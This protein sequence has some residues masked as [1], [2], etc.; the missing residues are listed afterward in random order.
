MAE[1]TFYPSTSRKTGP[2]KFDADDFYQRNMEWKKK[3]ETEDAEKQLGVTRQ[4]TVNCILRIMTN[5]IG[6]K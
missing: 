6:V 2:V 5:L 1:C 4:L 3:I